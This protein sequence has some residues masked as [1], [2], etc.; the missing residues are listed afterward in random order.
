MLLL[1]NLALVLGRRIRYVK[2]KDAGFLLNHIGLFI[3]LFSAGFGYADKEKYSMR[4]DEGKV[5]WRGQ[6]AGFSNVIELPVAI[7][8]I[9]FK[10]EEYTPKLIVISTESGEALPLEKPVYIETELNSES[11]IEGRS[12]R[13]DSLSIIN[14][15]PAAYITASTISSGQKSEGWVSCGNNSNTFRVV[16]LDNKLCIAMTPPEPKSFSSQIEVAIKKG[17]KKT[18]V[19]SVNH[20][21]TVGSWK[22]Y[23]YSY[24]YNRGRNSD[25]SVFQLVYDPWIIPVFIGIILLF[26]GTI[27]LFWKGGRR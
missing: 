8:L 2:L 15:A 5:E 17:A 4:V 1:V 20:P 13:I 22:I 10:M 7:K 24:D 18:G 14:D 19:V 11:V 16:G 6:R 12:I 3:L 27:S 25:Y 21:F 23:Q 9:D 26:L